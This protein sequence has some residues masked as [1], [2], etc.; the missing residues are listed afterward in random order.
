M[1]R[2]II[3]TMMAAVTLLTAEAQNTTIDIIY[4]GTTAE[5]NIPDG[6]TDVTPTV[7]GANVAI[8]SLTSTTEY[9]Y[10]LS[11]SST[12]GSLLINGAY[13][14]TLLLAGLDLTNA[15]GGAAIDIE[16]GKRIAVELADGTTNRLAD[17]SGAQKAALYFKGH[18]EFEG[19]GTL[20][21]TGRVKHAI[22]AKEYMEL[23]G[24]TGTI[25]VLGAQSDGLHCGKGK[26]NNEHNYF[27]MKGGN[28][29]IM[30]V[31]G[32]GIDSDD[33]GTIRMEGGVI[34]INVPDGA[35]GLKADSIVT[36]S[37]GTV[38][39]AVKG[40]DSE[41]IRSRYATNIEG[42]Q[43]YIVVNG[44]GSK[45]IKGKN[46]TEAS[47]VLNGG[48]VNIS[49]GETHIQVLGGNLTDATTSEINKCMGLS[50]DADLIQSGGSVN[51]TALGSEAF[52]Y[53]VKGSESRT[54]G[55]IDCIQAP[56]TINTADYQYDMT[57]YMAV[58]R[59]S[60]RLTDFKDKAIGAFAADGQCMGYAIFADSQYGILR[61]YSNSTS[62]QDISFR[63]YDYSTQAEYPLMPSQPVAFASLSN[64]GNPS[65]PLVLS[66]SGYQQGDVNHDGK[67]DKSD[68]DAITR[69]L[70]GQ[71]PNVFF[72][73]Q[74]DLNMDGVINIVD[75]TLAIEKALGDTDNTN[76]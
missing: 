1:K 52:T 65:S 35:T 10:R 67:I 7:E 19:G 16:C 13:K 55:T 43:L 12:D 62:A 29:S 33:Y 14:L 17:V 23:K 59:G 38:N 40:K 4:K 6:I 2:L 48:Y 5:V 18:A 24:S 74:A 58:Q 68:T 15:H 63:L 22:C 53:N 72:P 49:G 30:N 37:G 9:T 47:T 11:G 70:T 32:D 21:V 31:G 64:V 61:I 36:V 75:V 71:T 28:V 41:G 46:Y 25:N 54:N 76:Q 20:N 39:I 34:S 57:A 60:S 27:L 44:D 50:V 8:T 73:E 42:G 51:I 26:I 3:T 69:H 45:A 66:Y 56:W